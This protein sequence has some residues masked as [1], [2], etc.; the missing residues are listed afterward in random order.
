M[1]VA[2]D[3]LCMEIPRIEVTP[4]TDLNF[5]AFNRQDEELDSDW[6]MQPVLEVDYDS[7]TQCCIDTSTGG[8][9]AFADHYVTKRT[10]RKKKGK[11]ADGVPAAED[12]TRLGVPSHARK[13]HIDMEQHTHIN[14]KPHQAPVDHLALPENMYDRNTVPK[15]SLSNPATRRI[16]CGAAPPSMRMPR[17]GAAVLDQPAAIDLQLGDAD[18]VPPPSYEVAA[19]DVKKRYSSPSSPNSSPSQSPQ[20]SPHKTFSSRGCSLSPPAAVV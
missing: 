7:E 18:A 20:P 5:L 12:A 8:P 13:H 3:V 14:K 10:K 4:N 16:A 19:A 17:P 1:A 6:L 2:A 15:G 9:A 11:A